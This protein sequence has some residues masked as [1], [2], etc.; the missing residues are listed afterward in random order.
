MASGKIKN[1]V[2]D[3]GF[4]F[5]QVEGSSNDVFFH[6]SALVQGNFD[7]LKEGETVEF[8]VEPDPRNP[9]RQRAANVKAGA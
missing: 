6:S 1:L 8:D 9:S 7:S 2:R 3:R 4:G 5:I